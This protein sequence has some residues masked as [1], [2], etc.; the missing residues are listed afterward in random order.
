MNYRLSLD[1]TSRIITTL[2]SLLFLW[3][4]FFQWR[5]DIDPGD[6]TQVGVKSMV[7]LLLVSIYVFCFLYAPTEYLL[8]KEK[9]VIKRRFGDVTFELKEIKAVYHVTK[10]SMKWTIRSF[11]N[12]G[13]FG[14]FGY[15]SNYT[16]GNMI[17]YA[18]RRNN[19][20]M[21]ETMDNKRIV[22][23]PDDTTMVKEIQKLIAPVPA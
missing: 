19:Y 21:L 13:L 14:Y 4:I 7:T 16:H 3:M 10:D 12:G 20:V 18:T 1:W 6:M 11:G 8:T 5:I 17:W 2:I 15:F 9:L 23:T 22:L